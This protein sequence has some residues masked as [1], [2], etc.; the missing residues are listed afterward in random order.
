MSAEVG[1]WRGHHVFNQAPGKRW[2]RSQDSHSHNPGDFFLFILCSTQEAG[3]TG[4]DQKKL[5]KST[6]TKHPLG[7]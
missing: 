5:L 3:K 4:P 1:L 2:K 7:C 6:P